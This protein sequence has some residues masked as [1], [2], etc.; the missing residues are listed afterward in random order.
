M[1]ALDLPAQTDTRQ[2]RNCGASHFK[3]LTERIITK[4]GY[5]SRRS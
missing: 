1:T 5:T 4:F 2:R 3:N